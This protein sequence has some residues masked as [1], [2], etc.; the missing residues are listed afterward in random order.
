[1]RAGLEAKFLRVVA[2]VGS[3][4]EPERRGWGLCSMCSPFLRLAC[5]SPKAR[6]ARKVRPVGEPDAEATA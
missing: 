4:R 5:P 3:L 2:P 6:R 1:M